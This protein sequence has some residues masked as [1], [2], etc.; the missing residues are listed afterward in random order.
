MSRFKVL[1]TVFDL[2][3]LARHRRAQAVQST[4]EEPAVT[5]RSLDGGVQHAAFAGQTDYDEFKLP[6]TMSLVIVL[7]ASALLQVSFFIVVSS[8]DQYA[9]HLGGTATFSGLVIGIPTVFSGLA[10]VPLM[11]LDQGGYKRPLH[12]A[13]AS[14]FLGNVLYSLAYRANFLY[15]ILLGRIVS[16]FG[17]T[18]WMYSKRYCSDPRIVGVRRRTMLAGWLVLG[19]GGGMTIG[20]F[21]GGLFYKV[22]F[23]NGVFNGYT[24]PT[25]VL[26]GVWAVFWVFSALCFEDVPAVSRT[27]QDIEL[28][29]VQLQQDSFRDDDKKAVMTQEDAAPTEAGPSAIQ[30]DCG[31]TKISFSPLIDSPIR[32]TAQTIEQRS[33]SPDLG[34][35]QQ[36]RMSGPQWGVTATMCWFAMTCFFILG[37]W[38]ANIPVF[39][40]SDSTLNPFHFSPTAAGNLI[41]LGGISSLPFLVANVFVARRVQDRHTLAVGTSIGLAGLL[42]A[43]AIMSSRTVTYGSLFVCWFLI[44]LGFNL[45]STVTL[46]LLSKQLPGQWNS[47]ISMA[48]Q[49]S[50]YT[51]RVT[52]A[53]WGGAGVKIGMLSFV[54]MQVA[55]V[56]VGAVM[57]MTLW[58]NLK[59]KTG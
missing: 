3:P 57:F 20:P 38:E 24:A 41:A 18:F 52:G 8:S 40:G 2:P 16:G 7:L 36:I 13:C 31:Q 37:A 17:F 58:R 4:A 6:K 25:W 44:A 30:N 39:T 29:P 32:D 45:S 5:E 55:L 23:S 22:G 53:V 10:L 26:A 43:I 35:P 28:Q 48:I 11:K 42:I 14:A 19:Q 27:A 15:L 12:F 1:S 46:S 33:S 56:A 21:F 59:A 47:R 54:G 9:Q 49:Y 50:N 51:G 34:E